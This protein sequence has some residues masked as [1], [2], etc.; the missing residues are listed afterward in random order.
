MA[1]ILYSGNRNAS[2]WAFRAWLALKEQSIDFEEIIVDI[3]RPKRWSNL[4]EIGKFSPP[5][6]VPVLVDND[7]VIFDSNAIM[8]Y[9]NELGGGA[10]LPNDIKLRAQ[11]RSLVGW[12]HSNF[13]KV[14]PCLSFES[15]FYKEKKLLTANEIAAIEWVYSIWENYLTES[16]GGYLIGSY[17]LADIILVPSVLRFK[18]HHP[19]A[20]QFPRTQEWMQRLLKRPYVQEWLTDAYEQE[21]IYCAGYHSS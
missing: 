9:A 13:A 19:V 17:S 20:D 11:A 6:A 5:A 14:C 15:V 21:P 2:S 18:S 3:R 12:Q 8:E 10:L 16:S 4:A 7:T 1:R